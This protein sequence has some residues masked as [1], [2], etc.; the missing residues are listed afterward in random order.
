MEDTSKKSKGN[1]KTESSFPPLSPVSNDGDG[2]HRAP[3]HSIARHRLCVDEGA[4]GKEDGE[5]ES[6]VCISVHISHLPFVNLPLP[7]ARGLLSHHELSVIH[8][9]NCRSSLSLWPSVSRE[10]I[11][12]DGL[13]RIV[14]PLTR[15]CRPLEGRVVEVRILV[16]VQIDSG[17]APE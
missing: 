16:C 14:V 3:A 4:A 15:T 12:V 9:H 7:A 6:R 17:V 11:L 13:T 10:A 8:F 1:Q 2:D 5:E